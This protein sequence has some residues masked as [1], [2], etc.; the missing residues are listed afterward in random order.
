MLMLDLDHIVNPG[1][2]DGVN[3][4]STKYYISIKR[5][6]KRNLH[7]AAVGMTQ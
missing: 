1:F 7:V 4:L 5:F 3:T 6:L 2:A